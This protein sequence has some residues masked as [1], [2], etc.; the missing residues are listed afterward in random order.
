[1]MTMTESRT[2]ALTVHCP[3]CGRTMVLPLPP[4]CD[5][6]DAQRLAGCVVCDGCACRPKAQREPQ[7]AR[8]PYAD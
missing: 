1:M 4:D 2:A 6:P 7:Q 3:K 5:L 8:L